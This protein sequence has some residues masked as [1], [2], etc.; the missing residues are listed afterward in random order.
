MPPLIPLTRLRTFTVH[1]RDGTAATVRDALIDDRTLQVQRLALTSEDPA[2]WQTANVEPAFLRVDPGGERLVVDVD[3][4][5]LADEPDSASEPSVRTSDG[6]TVGGW[7]APR[8]S[9]S[10]APSS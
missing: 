8:R 10:R 3:D 1:T 7:P 5:T 6:Q 4:R 2:H 9:T